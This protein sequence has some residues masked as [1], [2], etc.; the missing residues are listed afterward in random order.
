L[1]PKVG[2]RKTYKRHRFANLA[3]EEF[4]LDSTF[5]VKT[6]TSLNAAGIRWV[7]PRHVFYKD[8]N[9]AKRRYHPDIYLPD[10]DVYIEPKNWFLIKQGI[11]H[12]EAA[13]EQNAIRVLILSEEFL[14]YSAFAS[15]LAIPSKGATLLHVSPVGAAA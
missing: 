8:Q 5:E 11:S 15:E 14:E 13:A 7:V 12:V 10:F 9:G 6:A 1:N 4:W 2:G 3:G